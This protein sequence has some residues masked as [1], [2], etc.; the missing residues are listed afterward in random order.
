LPKTTKERNALK[1]I[2]TSLKKQSDEENF[3]EATAL[4]IKLAKRSSVPSEITQLFQDQACENVSAKSSSF[5]LLLRAVRDFVETTEQHLLPLTGALPDM[6]ATSAGYITLQTLYRTKAQNDLAA[7]KLHLDSLLAK[8][9]LP[10]DA[11]PEEQISTFVKHAGFVAVIRG[12]NLADG[13][14]ADKT[15][16]QIRSALEDETSLLAFLVALRASEEFQAETGRWPGEK[17]PEMDSKKVEELAGGIL[18]RAGVTLTELP[19][20]VVLAVLEMYV[21]FG[22]CWLW[23]KLG[24]RPSG[25]RRA[26]SNGCSAWWHRG[27]RSHQAHYS[28]VYGPQRHFGF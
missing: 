16:E 6:K 15:P 25:R 5:W 14:L 3:D 10:S 22:N 4:V 17:E 11:I 9:G 20:Q 28:A 21:H 27:A 24:Q 12:T 2:I 7:V 19:E 26:A 23:L 8:V 13:K 18:K 1:A